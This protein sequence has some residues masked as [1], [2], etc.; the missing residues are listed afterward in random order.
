MVR[1]SMMKVRY[2]HDSQYAL[3]RLKSYSNTLQT[4]TTQYNVKSQGCE[5]LSLEWHTKPSASTTPW[6]ILS[7]Q[8]E[9]KEF[10]KCSLWS[11]FKDLSRLRATISISGCHNKKSYLSALWILNQQNWSFYDILSGRVFYWFD[12]SPPTWG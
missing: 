9:I 11:M 7:P 8:T 5:N 4:N 3:L 2:I 10:N 12:I 1:K 6:S